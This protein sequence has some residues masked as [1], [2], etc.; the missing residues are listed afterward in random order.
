[1]TDVERTADGCISVYKQA[2]VGQERTLR[3]ILQ[4]EK[5]KQNMSTMNRS[6]CVALGLLIHLSCNAQSGDMFNQNWINDTNGCRVFNSYPHQGETV[7]W[8]GACVN[9]YAEGIGKLTWYEN[10]KLSETNEGSFRNGKIDGVA[11]IDSAVDHYEGE[12]RGGVRN[13]HGVSISADGERYDG[14]WK[15]GKAH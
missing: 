12:F 9:G 8:T 7:V 6:A 3:G 5:I 2:R 13:G 15:D 14:E 10:G 4:L 1:M 11:T